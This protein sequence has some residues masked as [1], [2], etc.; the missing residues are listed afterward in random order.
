M[1]YP[2]AP[3]FTRPNEAWWFVGTTLRSPGDGTAVVRA[4]QER[5]LDTMNPSA[6]YRYSAG[7]NLPRFIVHPQHPNAGQPGYDRFL[8]DGVLGASTTSMIANVLRAMGQQQAAGLVDDI[9]LTGRVSPQAMQAIIAY[10]TQ[11]SG[12][13]RVDPRAI[14]PAVS[15]SPMPRA[16]QPMLP[17]PNAE[18]RSIVQQA[19]QSAATTTPWRTIASVAVGVVAT[20]TFAYLF[21]RK[22]HDLQQTRRKRAQ[23][24]RR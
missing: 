11:P 16:A 2:N 6:V 3:D 1:G 19:T 10:A 23:R 15:I 5:L 22:E 18:E 4:A 21:W 7:W 9:A 13:V 17:A 8:V 20:G 12:D 14:L 24:R